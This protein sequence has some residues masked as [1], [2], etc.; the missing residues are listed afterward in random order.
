[1]DSDSTDV[2]SAGPWLLLPV[3]ALPLLAWATALPGC[4]VPC[5][6][7]GL[8][9]TFCPE[10]ETEVATGDSTAGDGDGDGDTAEAGTMDAGDTEACSVL[11]VILIPQTPT[12]VLLVDQS[13]SMD[14]DFGGDTRWNVVT[15]VL[16]DPNGGIVPQF[17]GNIRFGLALYTSDTN[18]M[19][20]PCP[21]LTE[22][23]PA[24]NNF[25]AID[26]TLGSNAPLGDTPTG[27]S[28]DAVWQTLDVL[29]VP[30]KKFIVL[31]TD[32]EPDT[33]AVPNPNE[34]QPE[35]VAAAQGAFAAG[36]QTYIISVGDQ[37]S[38][39]HLQDMAN[40]GQGVQPGDPDAEFYQA[41]DQAAL[42]TA[43]DQIL[44]SVRSCQLDLDT[45]LTA[46][47]AENCTVV[48]NGNPVGLDD[49]NGWSLNDPT[50]VELL[51]SA[52]DTLQ[53]GTSSVQMEC[54]CA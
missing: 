47:D 40:A 7:D 3:L 20:A 19:N 10:A 51:G 41:L 50:E 5:L 24:L 23:S 12:L 42:V 35:S 13:L 17:E 2:R 48:I 43:F 16:T 34:G 4:A 36:I 6:D 32:G 37:V 54:I 18:D 1:M 27:E 22:V 11:D 30:G 31:A 39:A 8:G 53:D 44:A 29:D 38:N 9:Q 52:C 49:P 15:N 46:E 33:C 25:G 28:L 21:M 45:P 14:S 26:T